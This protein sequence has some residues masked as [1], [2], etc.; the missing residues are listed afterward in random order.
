MARVS[1]DFDRISNFR[2]I[3]VWGIVAALLLF[4]VTRLLII[5]VISPEKL[6]REGN[7]RVLR[8]FSFE[9]PR[10]LITDRRGK[11]LAISVP[12]KSVYADARVMAEAGFTDDAAQMGKLAAILEVEESRLGELLGDPARRSVRLKRYL[13]PER[14]RRLEALHVPGLSIADNY[15]RSY[16]TGEVNA[17]L[18]GMLNADGNGVYGVEQSFNSYLAATSSKSMAKKDLHGHIIE[19]MGV[20]QEGKAGGN[21]MLSVD[22]RLQVFAYN[23]LTEAVTH[24]QADHGNAI[25]MDVRTGEVLAMVGSPSFDPNE[26]SRFRPELALNR[27]LADS[28]EPGSTVKPLVALSALEAGV[29]SWSETFDTRPYTVDGKRISDSHPMA[30]GSLRDILKYSSNTGMARIAQRMGPLK[31]LRTLEQFGLGRHTSSGLVGEVDGTLNA[32][33][34]FWAEIDKATLGFGYGIAVTA[35]QLTSAYATLA[36][37]GSRVRVSLL[38]SHQ[39]EV[40]VQV[41]SPREVRRLHE[42]L[43]TIVTEGTGTVASISRYR[44]AGKTGTARIAGAG[45]YAEKKYIATFAGFAPISSP[46]FALVVVIKN[47]RSGGIYGGQVSG[48]V[49]QKIM[50]RALQMYNIEPDAAAR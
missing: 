28:F 32:G 12:V 31:I 15:Q 9:P 21:L 35:M 27:A 33:R 18:V 37:Y 11:I 34:R 8:A 44:I 39:P 26:R 25:L 29:T 40:G 41:A 38:R 7:S 1:A 36:N 30:S 2:I 24:H 20:I 5:Q 10:G 6:I 42:A 22:D 23:A 16:P 43:E 45:G 14:A 50:T 13:S 49:F 48:P 19:N 3:M 46:R 17:Q 47:P 4:L